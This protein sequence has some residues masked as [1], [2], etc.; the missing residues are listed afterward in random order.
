M[1]TGGYTGRLLRL[2]MNELD[3]SVETPRE[4]DL[5]DLIG[6][7]GLG[8]KYLY[9]EVPAHADALGPDNK[10]V[11]MTGPLTGT[12]APTSGRH[13][14][15]TKSP[16]TG[17]ETTAHA[18]G[19]WGPELKFA[20]YDGIIVEGQ[21]EK[22]VYVFVDDEE[23]HFYKADGLWGRD[24]IQT[25]TLIKRQ[26]D[27][28]KLN[29][30]YIGPAGE[31]LVKYATIMNDQQ[32]SASRGGPGAVMGSKKLKAIAVRGTRDVHAANPAKY[33][34]S[35]NEL[36]DT[37]YDHVVTGSLFPAYG[38][39]GIMGLMNEKGVLPTKNHYTGN[40]R[41]ADKISG[42]AMAKTMLTKTRGCFCCT[43]HCTRVIDI[44]YGPYHGIRGKGPDYDSTV[45][46][47]SQC[48]NDNLEAIAQANI[49]CDQYGLDTVS[50]GAT[51]AWA[52]ELYE[53]GI[54]DKLDTR[55][56]ELSWGNHE[57]MTSMVPKIATRSEFGA[58][59]ADGLDE[60]AKKIGRGSEKY[61][62]CV[63]NLDLPGIEARGS[64]GMA[65]GY[66]TDNRGGD[67]LRPFASMAE[68]FGF[69]SKELGM[70]DSFDPLSEAGKAQWMIPCQ[71]Y[72]VAVNSLVVC[73]FTVIA[74]TVEPSQYARHLSALT[75]FSFDKERLL[76]AGERI[77][78]LQRAFN[79]REGFTRKDDRLPF[80][81]TE[82]LPNGPDAGSAV[83]LNRMLDEY[84]ELRG[85][86]KETGWPT[87]GK[88]RALR[89]DY[90][91]KDLEKAGPAARQAAA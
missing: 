69:R 18:G 17:L 46:F 73:M 31:N 33:Y 81:M 27:D 74:F 54:I 82:P 20:G 24:T 90:V 89:L 55:G 71:N 59:L 87:P 48:G 76:E 41:G 23:V 75:G 15:V 65:L 91:V 29:I 11:F 40:F 30:T 63:K 86:D 42:Q 47:G 32:R 45:A 43:I 28:D 38:V 80:R 68:C 88:L 25:D 56:V 16:L 62:Q 37:C 53:K 19:Y 5:K 66:A 79:A 8:I 2:D 12:L 36:L 72:F 44:E 51:I 52:M 77:W 9:D 61:I 83:Y 14:V 1:T 13:C 35:M 34:Q 49:L 58:V 21:S 67:N 84:Y 50:A 78:N 60:A 26:L 85:W 3:F 10:L 22:P 39:T 64:K 57:A 70:P 7:E 4:E 6:G